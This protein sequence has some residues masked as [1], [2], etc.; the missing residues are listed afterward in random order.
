MGSRIGE[1]EVMVQAIPGDRTMPRFNQLSIFVGAVILLAVPACFLSIFTY[2]TCLS[3]Y[4]DPLGLTMLAAQL[5]PGVTLRV[6]PIIVVFAVGSSILWFSQTRRRL[7]PLLAATAGVVT[8]PLTTLNSP[9]V[10]LSLAA[11]C[12]GFVWMIL[13]ELAFILCTSR[14]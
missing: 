3:G 12:T 9:H 10:S 4:R 8:A 5:T 11:V 13:S 6:S 7:V 2:L 14:K 1:E